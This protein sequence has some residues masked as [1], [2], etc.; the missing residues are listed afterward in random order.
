MA[1]LSGCQKLNVKPNSGVAAVINWIVL[2]SRF[3]WAGLRRQWSTGYWQDLQY[4]VY[5]G[6]LR[7]EGLHILLEHTLGSD[8]RD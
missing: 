5:S 2:E 7:P 6:V 4:Y 8:E 1:A 3:T